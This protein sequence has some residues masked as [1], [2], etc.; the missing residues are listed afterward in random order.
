M[1]NTLIT[2]PLDRR[3]W[4]WSLLRYFCSTIPERKERL[5]AVYKLLQNLKHSSYLF[6]AGRKLSF[7]LCGRQK[8]FPTELQELS[9][10]K[11]LYMEE[12]TKEKKLTVGNPYQ[13]R[14][15]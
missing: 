13:N 12:T 9:I 1:A 3:L 11:M 5:L 4:S 8:R 15:M 7:S 10:L 14:Y 6:S 2:F